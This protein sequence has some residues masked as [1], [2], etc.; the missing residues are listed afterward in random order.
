V[1]AAQSIRDE[2]MKIDHVPQRI[3]R[4]VESG[5]KSATGAPDRQT[6]MIP[7][8][9]WSETPAGYHEATCC[10]QREMIENAIVR[11]HGNIGHTAANLGLSRHALR[12]QM[13]KLGMA[14]ADGDEPDYNSDAGSVRER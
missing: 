8:A 9:K 13:V 7:S 12:H 5:D 3:V 14:K 4:E 1:F 2:S 11:S 6:E 10:F